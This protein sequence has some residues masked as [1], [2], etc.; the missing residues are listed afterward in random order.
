[1]VAKKKKQEE[2]IKEIEEYIESLG[3][4]DQIMF[5]SS[6]LSRIAVAGKFSHIERLGMLECAKL[7]VINYVI[8]PDND[9]HIINLSTN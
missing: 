1:M 4:E 7:D 8:N 5:V 2:Y 6:V 9:E 3:D